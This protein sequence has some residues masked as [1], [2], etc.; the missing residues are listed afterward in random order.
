[1]SKKFEEILLEDVEVI[2]ISSKGKGVCK[3]SSGK[4][5]F[6]EGTVPGDKISLKIKRKKKNYFEGQIVKILKPSKNRIIPKCEHFGLCGG[7]KLQNLS[8]EA[9]IEYKQKQILHNLTY[10]SEMKIP[11]IS[12][13]KKAKEIYFYRNKMEFSFSEQRWLTK[14]ELNGEKQNIIKKGLGFH[15]SGAWNKII[16]I[17]NCHLQKDPSNSIRNSIREFGIEHNLK[18]F[19]HKLQKGFLRNL[20]IRTTSIGVMV[21]IQFYKEDKNKRVQLMDHLIKN[22]L[23]IKSLLY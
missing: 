6:V 10:I 3:D 2:D 23:E 20:M 9:Q 14:D 19:D 15:K 7:C 11:K 4:V 12:R 21:L 1:M 18:F 13:L 5:I 17:K 16:D 22:F 8:Y